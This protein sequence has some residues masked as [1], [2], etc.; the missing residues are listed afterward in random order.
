MSLLEGDRIEFIWLE[1]SSWQIRGSKHSV[2][3]LRGIVQTDISLSDQEIRDAS[4]AG[5]ANEEGSGGGSVEG[6][7]WPGSNVIIRFLTG[8]NEV[9][10]KSESVPVILSI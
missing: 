1:D 9:L 5:F 3:V 6:A 8:D 2:M 7:C 4:E 10:S